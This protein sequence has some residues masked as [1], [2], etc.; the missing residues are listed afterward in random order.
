MT[1]M[2]MK[3]I[4]I[5]Q[6]H[7]WELVLGSSGSRN[8]GWE[9]LELKMVEGCVGFENPPRYPKRPMSTSVKSRRVEDLL[10]DEQ[11]DVAK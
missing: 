3:A 6:H 9:M 8:E 1:A 2:G 4:L 5:V 11:Q 7:A 10:F